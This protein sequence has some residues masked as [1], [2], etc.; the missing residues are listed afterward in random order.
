MNA[1]HPTPADRSTPSDAPGV[2]VP[3]VG[4][5]P[6]V[7]TDGGWFIGDH[8]SR[9]HLAVLPEGFEH[10]VTGQEPFLVPWDRLM[11]LELGVTSGRFFSTPAGG[12][13]TRHDGIGAHGS[14]LDTMVRR[15]YDVWRP[16]F[17]HHRHWYPMPEITVLRQLLGNVVDLGRVHRLGDDAWL[18]SVVEALAADRLLRRWRTSRAVADGVKEIILHG[19]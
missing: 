16:R 13:L 18:T 15:P 7:R 4:L 6:L 14:W 12:L 8:R 3:P 9:A 5:G 19:A 10:R 2:H 1:N 17:V 11:S